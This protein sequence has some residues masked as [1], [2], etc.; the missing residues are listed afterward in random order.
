M[1]REVIYNNKGFEFSFFRYIENDKNTSANGY[2]QMMADFRAGKPMLGS[3]G[4]WRKG[5][6][7]DKFYAKMQ[8]LTPKQA[9]KVQTAF[10]DMDAIF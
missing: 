2:R 10:T 3:I 7:A 1:G 5:W 8:H 6:T 4:T 9:K